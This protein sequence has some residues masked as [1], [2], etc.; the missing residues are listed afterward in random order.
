MQR[1]TLLRSSALAPLMV[2]PR[3]VGAETYPRT[4]DWSGQIWA[5]K[6]SGARVTGPGGNRFSSST[7][8]VCV[9]EDGALQLRITPAGGQWACAEVV[10]GE[11]GDFGYG[12]YHWVM[13]T[14]AD[15]VRRWAILGLFTW[16]AQ[17]AEQANRE[18]DVEIGRWRGDAG[19]HNGL[20]TVQPYTLPGAS[21]GYPIP[22]GTGPVSVGFTWSAGR[23]EFKAAMGPQLTPT[24][25]DD[26]IASWTTSSGVPTPGLEQPRINLWLQHHRTPKPE[27]PITVRMRSFAFTSTE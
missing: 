3:R 20:F 17:S 13:E 5:V 2:L 1:R 14:P 15:A 8:H 7:D 21:L 27:R 10:A 9:T 4:I 26:V 6:D 12:T 25:L 24:D 23:V 22:S 19:G 11:P 16:D 18:I